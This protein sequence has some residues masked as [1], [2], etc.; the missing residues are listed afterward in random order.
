M[1]LHFNLPDR[2]IYIHNIYN[3]VNS[4]EVSISI[5]ILKHRLAAHPN[6]EHILLRDFNL[7]HEVWGRSRASKALIEKLEELLIVAQRWKIEQMVL[8]G[9]AT[10]EESTGEST[11]HLIFAM[12]LLSE[13]LISCN[14]AGDFDNDSNH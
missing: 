5:P 11:I 14:I 1:S 13:S 6:E 4:E 2:C 8:V 12:S 10:Y 3:P 9:T 7:H